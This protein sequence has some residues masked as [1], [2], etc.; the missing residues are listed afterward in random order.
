MIAPPAIRPEENSTPGPESASARALARRGSLPVDEPAHDPAHEH[1]RRGRDGQIDADRDRE[2][3]QPEDLHRDRRGR[4]RSRM[5]PHGSFCVRMPSTTSAMICAF[6]ESSFVDLA[7]VV[8]RPLAAADARVERYLNRARI[9]HE[10]AA[11]RRVARLLVQVPDAIARRAWRFGGRR[12]CVRWRARSGPACSIADTCD[13]GV[14]LRHDRGLRVVQELDV[15]PIENAP[16]SRRRRAGR[17]A[18][19]PASRRRGS[20]S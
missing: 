3:G 20:R 8:V 6:G 1:R 14:A 9:V 2:R 12:P 4:R 5:S 7:A 18:A 16:T 19:V 15:Q 13:A 11:R 17:S 10:I